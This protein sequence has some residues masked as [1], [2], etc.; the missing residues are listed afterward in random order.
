MIES[1]LSGGHTY[2]PLVRA[3]SAEGRKL[4]RSFEILVDMFVSHETRYLQIPL[5]A[6]PRVLVQMITRI[7][8]YFKKL[9]SAPVSSIHLSCATYQRKNSLQTRNS[10]VMPTSSN[11]PR[12]DQEENRRQ[13]DCTGGTCGPDPSGM[14]PQRS[15]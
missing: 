9:L 2:G 10:S 12:L 6:F 7:C 3:D 13:R 1:S 11:Y 15:V 14:R 5:T 8:R 4:F